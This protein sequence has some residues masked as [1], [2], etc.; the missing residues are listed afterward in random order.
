[1]ALHA[2][3]S[4]FPKLVLDLIAFVRIY[5]KFLLKQIDKELVR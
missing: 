2:V 4:H 5:I 3:I 1:M